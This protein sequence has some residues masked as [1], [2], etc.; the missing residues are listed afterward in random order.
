[1]SAKMKR[2]PM[3]RNTYK[4]FL[5]EVTEDISI[6]FSFISENNEAVISGNNETLC[7]IKKIKCNLLSIV[8]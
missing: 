6:W 3:Q 5:Q 8:F 7:Y 4:Q 1:M 2:R